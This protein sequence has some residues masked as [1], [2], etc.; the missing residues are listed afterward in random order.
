VAGGGSAPGGPLG[1]AGRRLAGPRLTRP[2]HPVLPEGLPDGGD[3]RGARGGA[4]PGGPVSGPA[5][6]TRPVP[7]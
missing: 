6:A 4:L 3:R 2:R 7:R 5:A 1:P